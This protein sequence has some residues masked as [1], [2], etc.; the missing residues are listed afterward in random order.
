MNEEN[1]QRTQRLQALKSKWKKY[2][3]KRWVLPA[4]FLATASIVISGVLWMQTDSSGNQEATP[5]AEKP[6]S[7]AEDEYELNEEAVPVQGDK[8]EMFQEPVASQEDIT[9]VTPFYD[10]KASADEQ[11]SALVFYNNTYHQ[12]Q[13]ID[14]A[15][16][17]GESFDVFASMSGDV[18][19]A[20]EDQ[21][22]G[23]VVHVEH[24]NGVTTRYLS[25]QETAVEQGDHVSQGQ[26]IGRAGKSNFNKDAGVH[27]HFEIRTE[28]GT[29]VNPIDYYKKAVSSLP[30]ASNNS[31]DANDA[32]K[33]T[34]ES[35]ETTESSESS[36]STESSE[37]PMSE[38]SESSESSEEPMSPND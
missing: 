8:E 1:N 21:L 6:G 10:V 2:T 17:S 11:Q 16:E 32:E 5:M 9:V 14:Y 23:K 36:E 33:T 34:N 12:S 13:G 15:K 19:K 35:S 22:L 3:Q 18:V 37:E 31:N 26:L 27:L 38:S 24:E 20:E 25:L 7:Y 28:D 29:A 4:V 30:E